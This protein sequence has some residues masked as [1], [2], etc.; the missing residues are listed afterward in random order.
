MRVHPQ[1]G[2]ACDDGDACTGLGTCDASSG[3]S[4]AT[5]KT[6]NDGN[7]CTEDSCD[8]VLG[9]QHDPLSGDFCDDGDACTLGDTCLSGAC[10]GEGEGCDDGNPCTVDVCTGESNCTHTP[11]VG[12]SCDD[13]DTCTIGIN[14]MPRGSCVG[15]PLNCDDGEECTDDTCDPSSG[16][17]YTDSVSNPGCPTFDADED[18]VL[19]DAD[20]CPLVPNPDQADTDE[21]GPGDLMCECLSGRRGYRQGENQRSG[22][23]PGVSV[24]GKAARGTPC[25]CPTAWR[26]VREQP[27]PV[28]HA[29][30]LFAT[31]KAN[32]CG[33]L[34]SEGTASDECST[35]IIE[36]CDPIIP[37]CTGL[38]TQA[39]D[40]DC[41]QG[42]ILHCDGTCWPQSYWEGLTGNGEC[43]EI[44]NCGR[45]DWMVGSA[46]IRESV[47]QGPQRIATTPACCWRPRWHPWAMA[48]ASRITTAARKTSMEGTARRSVMPQ[49]FRTV[50]GIASRLQALVDQ[51]GSGTCQFE[52]YCEALEYDQGDC[53][54]APFACEADEIPDC[55]GGC[56]TKRR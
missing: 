7:S 49:T 48:C 6:C 13:G 30:W 35:C 47:A 32:Q 27:S 2:V 9:C 14:A 28:A 8:S 42:T 41:P 33:E 56:V 55:I 1:V 24:Y 53:G 18:G 16:C 29:M 26:T 40:G 3:C 25:A 39:I 51:A 20:N 34:C 11:T 17:T 10:I 46:R 52:Y 22:R 12:E 19:G 21:T 43:D 23:K 36:Q 50:R 45:L 5:A 15:G 4:G 31:C 54:P 44:L 37:Q 38:G